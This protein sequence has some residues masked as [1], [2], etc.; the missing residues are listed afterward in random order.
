MLIK[1]FVVGVSGHN[2]MLLK[3]TGTTRSLGCGNGPLFGG[4]VLNKITSFRFL[5]NLVLPGLLESSNRHH[6]LASVDGKLF[7]PFA[8]ITGHLNEDELD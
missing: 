5:I 3:Y 4:L 2:E 8:N 1:L 6:V 7:G